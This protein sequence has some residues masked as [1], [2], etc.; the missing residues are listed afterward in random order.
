MFI[1]PATFWGQFLPLAVLMKTCLKQEMNQH[2]I[3]GRSW[4]RCV[5]AKRLRGLAG[6]QAK[7]GMRISKGGTPCC[8][9]LCAACLPCSNPEGFCPI[10]GANAIGFNQRWMHAAAAGILSLDFIYGA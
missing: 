10:W 4:P 6:I 1:L 9:G 2:L 5:Q 3:E 8:H 7:M